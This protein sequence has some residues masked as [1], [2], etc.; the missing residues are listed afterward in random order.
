MKKRAILYITIM[1]LIGFIFLFSYL[2]Q[3]PEKPTGEGPEGQP[4]PPKQSTQPPPTPAPNFTLESLSGGKVSP[5]DF[6]GRNVLLLDFWATDRPACRKSLPALAELEKEF[7]PR[8]L[9][10]ISINVKGTRGE[11]ARF[12]RKIG[13]KFLVLLDKDGSVARRYGVKTTPTFVLV[14]VRGGISKTIQGFGPNSKTELRKE[15]LLL[16]P[17]PPAIIPRPPGPPGGPAPTAAPP[18]LR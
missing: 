4:V 1:V 10:V 18:K 12:I 8:G 17:G 13:C 14:D 7:A 2:L 5:L 16:P 15:I 11:V 3:G 9:K 6:L